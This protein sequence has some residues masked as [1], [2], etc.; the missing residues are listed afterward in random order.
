MTRAK[1]ARISASRVTA[2]ATGRVTRLH[3]CQNANARRIAR[4]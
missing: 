3:R 4:F 1:A 2:N